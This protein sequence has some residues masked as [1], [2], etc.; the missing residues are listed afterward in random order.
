MPHLEPG[1]LYVPLP[2]PHPVTAS[3]TQN[4]GVNHITPVL[5]MTPVSVLALVPFPQLS[6]LVR[7]YRPIIPSP[8]ALG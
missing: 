7:S 4:G 3:V 5:S 2:P 8:C 6:P 1:M